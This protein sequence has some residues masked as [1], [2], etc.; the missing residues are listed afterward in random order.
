M[1]ENLSNEIDIRRQKIE[2]LKKMGEI[3]YKE[4]FERTCTIKQ[5][6][7]KLGERVKIAGRIVFRRIMG[8]FG[9]CQ[10]RDIYDKIQVSVGRNEF[11]E[12]DYQ[13]YKR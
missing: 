3:P 5:A 4:K 8:K 11:S 1:E 13:F 7:E 2:E 10:I 12:E 6:R 9:F